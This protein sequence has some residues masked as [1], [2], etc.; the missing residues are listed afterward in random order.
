ME[1]KK[2]KE[3][4]NNYYSVSMRNMILRGERRP[5]YTVIVELHKVHGVPFDVWIDIKSFIANYIPKAETGATIN[6]AYVLA[7]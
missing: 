4:L 2:L 3:I 7:Q 6:D 5:E 1:R